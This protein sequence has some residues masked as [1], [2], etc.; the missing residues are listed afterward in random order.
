VPNLVRHPKENLLVCETA[1]WRGGLLLLRH[2][3]PLT[4]RHVVYFCSGAY[5][6]EQINALFQGVQKAKAGQAREL[7][8][9][10]ARRRIEEARL[11]AE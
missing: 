2:V 8:A 6:T 3:T 5:T 1:V 11:A 9:K 4:R 7:L 10:R